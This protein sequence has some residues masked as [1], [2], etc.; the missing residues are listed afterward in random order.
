MELFPLF[1]KHSLHIYSLAQKKRKPP[2]VR[3][4]SSNEATGENQEV[5]SNLKSSD[6]LAASS[7]DYIQD[8]DRQISKHYNKWKTEILTKYRQKVKRLQQT[9]RRQRK[10]R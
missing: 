10:K 8:M 9:N 3:I 5:I 6:Q 7:S 2:A 4:T 1:L